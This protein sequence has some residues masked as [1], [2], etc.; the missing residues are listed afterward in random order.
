M[1][2][3]GQ[4]NKLKGWQK[5]KLKHYAVVRNWYAYWGFKYKC[6]KKYEQDSLDRCLERTVQ[7]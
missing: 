5:N 6:L 4:Y 7:V 3:K 1:N 2:I